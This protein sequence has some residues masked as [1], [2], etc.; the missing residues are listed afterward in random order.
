M[1]AAIVSAAKQEDGDPWQG[2]FGPYEL[3]A[4]YEDARTQAFIKGDITQDQYDDWKP[5]YK[6]P[7]IN[8]DSD[9]GEG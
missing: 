2:W 6:V 4:A 1:S 3:S 8:D 5:K 9:V 7:G